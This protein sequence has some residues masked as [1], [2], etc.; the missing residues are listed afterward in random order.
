MDGIAALT[1]WLERSH[2]QGRA[3]QLIKSAAA[4]AL[5]VL[6]ASFGAGAVS[7]DDCKRSGKQCKKNSQCCSGICHPPSSARSTASSSSTCCAPETPEVTCAGMCGQAIVN[8][9]GQTVQC[10]ACCVPDDRRTTCAGHCGEELENNC[11][12][13]VQC[14]SCADEICVHNPDCNS[15]EC[16][17]GNC[18]DENESPTAACC[19]DQGRCCDCFKDNSPGGSGKTYCGCPTERELCGTYPNDECCQAQD[20]CVDGGCIPKAFACPPHDSPNS[21]NVDCRGDVGSGCC[22]GVCCP[23]GTECGPSGLCVQALQTCSSQLDCNGEGSCTA[24]ANGDGVC[25]PGARYH[26]FSPQPGVTI[27]DCCSLGTEARGCDGPETCT[28]IE[29]DGCT[30]TFRGSQPRV[31]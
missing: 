10:P 23:A 25:C 26:Q 21:P 5:A 24:D 20:T 6:S 2:R 3:V 8:N 7:A 29:Y 22:G 16:C 30:A 1:R 18:C 27:R 11:G 19:P 17:V 13:L 9:C 14:G 28:P 12:V 31:T 15:G 4:S